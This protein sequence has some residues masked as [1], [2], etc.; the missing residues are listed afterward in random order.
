MWEMIPKELDETD[1][2]IIHALRKNGRISMTELGKEVFMTSQAVKNRIARLQDLGVVERRHGDTL[3]THQ[4]HNTIIQERFDGFRH[5]LA[6][7]LQCGVLQVAP[8]CLPHVVNVRQYV[9]F[10]ERGTG[11]NFHAILF[12]GRRYAAHQT[13]PAVFCSENGCILILHHNERNIASAIT[14]IVGLTIQIPQISVR[15]AGDLNNTRVLHG[16]RVLAVCL[17]LRLP[18]FAALI[19]FIY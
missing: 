8:A 9:P 12:L 13:F 11:V 19:L 6:V 17:P 18:E 7:R 2:K 14:R 15:V 1:M 10:A 4:R 5:F 3:I 16:V